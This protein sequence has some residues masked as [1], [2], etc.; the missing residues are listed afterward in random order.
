MFQPDLPPNPTADDI[1]REIAFVNALKDSHDRSLDPSGYTADM[2]MYDAALEDLFR[3]L[4]S[5]RREVAPGSNGESS[6][7]LTLQHSPGGNSSGSSALSR[8][9]SF[10]SMGD[11]DLSNPKR[12]S[13]N[14]SPAVTPSTPSTPVSDRLIGPWLKG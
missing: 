2:A 12:A 9:R 10:A 14:P 8:K 7:H 3:R 4:D 1:A 11:F 6:V 5:A 13:L